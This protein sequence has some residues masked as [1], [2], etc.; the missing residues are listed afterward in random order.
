MII[1]INKVHQS[2]VN[3]AVKLL[4]KYN[5]LNT[6]RDNASDIDEERLYKILDRKC[7]SSFDYYLDVL[8]SLPKR[9]QNN[10]EKSELY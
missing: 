3:K 8:Y 10:I 5:A 6:Q 1:A 7:A 9:E 2:K 4:T